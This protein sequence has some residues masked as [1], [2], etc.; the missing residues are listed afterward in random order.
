MCHSE[1][2]H[3]IKIYRLNLSKSDFE[4]LDPA[5]RKL[6]FALGLALNELSIFAKL[7]IVAS[8]PDTENPI[9]HQMRGAQMFIFLRTFIGKLHEAWQLYQKL[10]KK[11]EVIGK[12][13]LPE[14]D[15]NESAA[16][17]RLK[18]HFGED[19]PIPKIRNTFSF[20]YYDEDNKMEDSFQ[21]VPSSEDFNWYISEAAANSFFHASEVVV[22]NGVIDAYNSSNDNRLEI[23]GE[24]MNLAVTV[25]ADL[26]TFFSGL[27]R[28][29][30]KNR[31]IHAHIEVIDEI[32]P[33]NIDDVVFPFYSL[34]LRI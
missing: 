17:K 2:I 25:S 13:H 26:Q 22:T 1:N 19:S 18:K 12:I 23:Y 24:L 15:D 20:H 5:E 33:I 21:A 34:G 3:R 31:I 9:E 8:K 29:V 32:S 6:L 28:V 4:K 27:M 10:I 7:I 30:I 11:S 16:L 14:L